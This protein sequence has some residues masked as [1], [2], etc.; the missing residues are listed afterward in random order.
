MGLFSYLSDWKASLYEKRISE[1]QS[2]GHC[3]DCNGK[4]FQIPIVNE[5]CY[6][7]SYE[8]HGCNGTGSFSH[9]NANSQS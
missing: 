9:W 5:Y 2:L 4:G 7:E 8:C 6:P 1:A 3:P